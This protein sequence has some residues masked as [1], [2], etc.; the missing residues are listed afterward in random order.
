MNTSK[1][2]TQ[3]VRT[4]PNQLK[5][6]LFCHLIYLY[7]LYERL[8]YSKTIIYFAHFFCWEEE[9]VTS[10]G[11]L[12]DSVS[13]HKRNNGGVFL[14]AERLASRN[15]GLLW[16]FYC[17]IL[18]EDIHLL[19]TD[20][21]LYGLLWLMLFGYSDGNAALYPANFGTMALQCRVFLA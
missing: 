20:L 7:I 19:V 16:P 3:L 11:V 17:G 4:N 12:L 15:W 14:H 9:E 18:C 6:D 1:N 13:Y 8:L 21:Q 2:W 5:L 10:S